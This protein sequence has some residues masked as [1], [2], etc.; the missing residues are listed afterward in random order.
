MSESEN[1][2]EE[3]NQDSNPEFTEFAK[4]VEALLHNRQVNEAIEKVSVIDEEFP[5]NPLAMHLAGIVWERTYLELNAQGQ[6]PSLIYYEKAEQYFRKALQLDPSNFG[7]HGER[8]YAC[9]FVLG[10]QKDDLDRLRESY[11][12]A[13]VLSQSPEEMIAQN[14]KHEKAIIASGIARLTQL[15]D[16][17]EAADSEF[18]DLECPDQG[19]E[20]YFFCYYR[21]LVKRALADILQDQNYLIEAIDSFRKAIAESRIR[22][23]EY[24]L[25]DCLLLLE[26]PD[27]IDQSE[28][29]EYV[30]SL[31]E[32]YPHDPLVEKL[33]QRYHMRLKLLE[34]NY[35]PGDKSSEENEGP[36]GD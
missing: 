14:Y 16:D 25:A 20:R 21:A 5:D 7:L 23:I 22:T 6:N 19:R 17:W 30:N 35:D 10:T 12:I 34:N 15:K 2:P 4:E 28:M 18:E 31:L 24:L 1:T 27:P 36:T 3:K 13:D 29:K 11:H 8:L 26:K 9:L 33:G 32:R